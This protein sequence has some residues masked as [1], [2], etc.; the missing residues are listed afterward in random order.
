MRGGDDD[1]STIWAMGRLAGASY[2]LGRRMD[3]TIAYSRNQADS[4]I[5]LYSYDQNAVSISFQL[6]GPN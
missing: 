1:D 6:K 3:L 2:R 4:N 5:P